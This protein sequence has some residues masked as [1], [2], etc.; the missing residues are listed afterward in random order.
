MADEPVNQRVACKAVIANKDDK[1][2]LLREASTYEEGTNVGV[3]TC[4][5][6]G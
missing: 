4:L 3:L 1:V 2:L 5:V 6:G